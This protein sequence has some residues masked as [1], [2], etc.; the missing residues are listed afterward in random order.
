MV[1]EVKDSSVLD[2][3]IRRLK[4]V[5]GEMK[6]LAEDRKLLIEEFKEKLDMKAV[7]AAIKIVRIKSRLGDS[8]SDCEAYI[9]HID[10]SL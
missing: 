9:D 6:L 4:V 8:E 2:E 5:E 10:G 3:F 7:R 1:D